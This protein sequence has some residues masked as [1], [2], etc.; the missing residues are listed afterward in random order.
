MLSS[1]WS[2]NC[3]MQVYQTSYMAFNNRPQFIA[4]SI[5]YLHSLIFMWALGN[6]MVLFALR[7]LDVNSVLVKPFWR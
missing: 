7:M 3:L 6:Q 2:E 4:C 1:C 5:T